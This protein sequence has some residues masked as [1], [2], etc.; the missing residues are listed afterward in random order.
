MKSVTPPASSAK[1]LGDIRKMI[2]ETRSVVAATVNAGLTLLY[3]RIGK[4]IN[5]EIL[6]GKRADY[7]DQILATLSQELTQD[8]GNGFS[9]SALTR[10]VKFAE[11]FPVS[12]IV[13]TL[14]Q[15]LSW[16]HIRELLPLDQ[17]LQ[18]EFYSE[19]CRVERWSVRTLR[20]KIDSMLYERTALSRKPEKVIKAELEKL[21]DK[22]RMSPDIV[23][24]DPYILDFLGLQDRYMEKDLENAILRELE[25]FLLELGAGFTFIARQKRI[26]IDGDDFYL[27][28]L[29]YH[30]KLRRLIA[31]DLKLGRFKAAYKGQME[32]YLRW[33]AKHETEPGE[34]PPL[35][36]ILCAEG[37]REQIELLELGRSGIHVA[38]YLTELPPKDVLKRKLHEAIARS[39]MALENQSGEQEDDD[40]E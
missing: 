19:M 40:G 25:R 1:L 11:C 10:M 4:R 39:Q 27:D 17:P 16:S 24:K 3:W 2:E 21:R 13:A 28:L 37:S 36:L 23:F 7:G 38:Q 14:S 8:Y 32:L 30:R 12:Q 5:E 31:L 6:K 18:R 29:F 9:Y 20:Q 34:E 22:D 26:P 15:S 33:L 35:G